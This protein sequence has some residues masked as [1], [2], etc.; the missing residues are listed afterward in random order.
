[1]WGTRVVTP[2]QKN[3]RGISRNRIAAMNRIAAIMHM[4]G[5]K[6]KLLLQ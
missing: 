3:N 6:V 5:T 2:A 4:S 1:M